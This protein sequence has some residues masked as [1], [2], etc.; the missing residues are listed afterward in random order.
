LFRVALLC[1]ALVPLGSLAQDPEATLGATNPQ[2][3]VREYL[4][5]SRSGEYEKAALYLNL[6]GLPP[7][8][9]AARGPDLAR[10]L[11]VILD[12]TLWVD[13]EALS[14]EATGDP[15][16]GLPPG[17]DRI[18]T[19]QTASGPLD[20]LVERVRAPSTEP[21]WRFAGATVARIG[22]LYDEFGYGRL[23]DW[24]PE[25]LFTIRF[26]E[27]E[28]WQW[29][30]LITLLVVSW[31]VGSAG[32][33]ILV[34]VVRRLAR[35]TRST[36][37][38]HLLEAAASPLVLFFGVATFYAG[39]FGLALSVQ[40]RRVVT[41]ATKG[42]LILAITWLALRIV[43]V[44]AGG[45]ERRLAAR[46]D[47]AAHT[48]IQMGSRVTKVFL[49]ILAVLSALSNLGFN[50]TGLIAGLGVGGIA[51]ALAA[52]KTFENFFGG[53]SMLVD[54]PIQ[55]GEFC[56]YGD[57]IGTV[58][59]IGL[60]STRIRS[61]DRTL[62]TVPNAEFSSIQIENFAARDRIR[63]HTVIG[64]RYET[65]ADQLRWVL[66]EL[67][68]LLLSH[69]RVNPDPARVRFTGYGAYSLDLEIFAY[70]DTSDWAEFLA[71]REDLLLR[72]MDLVEESGSGFAFPSQTVYVGRD[73]GLDAE[74]SRSAASRVEEWRARDDL[75]LPDFPEDVA[76]KTIGT[77]EY[78]P[79]GSAL[80]S[81]DVRPRDPSHA[82]EDGDE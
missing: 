81:K 52:Q 40:A 25:P 28:L 16:D 61:L 35:R 77:A 11:K 33:L 38:D 79:E 43:D 75:Y 41:G 17:H 6:R 71:V 64:L 14:P 51:I 56:R 18:G 2:D 72:I 73:D 50:V 49:L 36:I 30:G 10:Q 7:K 58:E 67:R 82:G 76:R 63:F 1:V 9:R 34:P 24:L 46:G 66:I 29:L 27:I 69:P 26:L 68:R 8:R 15:E 78:P 12:Q 47:V 57:K 42:L 3:A 32:A 55:V 21:Q 59:Q 60:R 54:K 48:V 39:S 37:D 5:A 44:V 53:I 45:L 22:N 65:T 70:V 74:R 80:A 31:V 62:V 19:I 23:G 13:W 20:V 4:E